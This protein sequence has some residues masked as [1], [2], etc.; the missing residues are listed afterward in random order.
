MTLERLRLKKNADRR[1]K[2]GHLW[3]YSNEVDTAVTPLKGLQAGEQRLVESATGQ[4]LGV[5][6]V[7]PNNLICARL[8]SE[9]PDQPLDLALLKA[10]IRQALALRETFYQKPFYRL[11][12]GESDLLPGLIVDRFDAVLVV[13]LNTAGMD[14][15]RDE[16]L[17]AL[18]EVI[19]PQAIVCR[20][21]AG[22][23]QLEGLV[24]EVGLAWGELP[25]QVLAEEN[26]CVFDVPVLDGQKTGWFYDHQPNRAALL[27]LVKGK[28]V[29]DVFS[30]RGAWG[31]PLAKAGAREVVFLDASAAA[32]EGVQLNAALN[33]VADRVSTLC[34]DA[35]EGLQQL[36]Q[37]GEQFDLVILDP[38]AFIKRKKDQGPG[39]HAYQRLNREA[40][41][42]LPPEDGLL[43]SGSCSMHLAEERLQDLVR[44]A[45][46]RQQRMAQLVWRG[47]Q[48]AD[49]PVHPA[50][51]ETRYLK[52]L[53]FRLVSQ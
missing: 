24:A 17:L 19:Q 34:A 10:R 13:Q 33:G 31:M 21:D 52:A 6:Y 26:G 27:P 44:I 32:L 49:H 42:L 43:L 9:K 23:R 39:E 5:A 20:N 53:L 16:V 2:A 12:Y 1:L 50:I 45:A 46:R 36:Q 29:L 3:I 30:Y 40:M 41:K 11:V 51:P 35:F 18:R 37:A 48:G 22:A 38:P 14:A 4:P 7:H 25:D 8:V 15:L 28:R 47:G